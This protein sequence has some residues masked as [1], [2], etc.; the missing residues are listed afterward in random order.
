MTRHDQSE[1]AA[2]ELKGLTHGRRKPR[3][4]VAVPKSGSVRVPFGTQAEARIVGDLPHVAIGIPE[5]SGVA[6]VERLA[7][8]LRHIRA[9]ARSGTD[10]SIHLLAGSDVVREDDAS[11]R[12]GP[13]VFDSGIGRDLVTAPEHDR[14]PA[15][16]EEDRLLHLLATPAKL[17]VEGVRP[18][19]VRDTEGD[20]TDSL[21]HAT[22]GT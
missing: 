7:R 1:D 4:Y 20:E 10:D 11:E 8:D 9:G 17:L 5:E 16:L 13:V 3:R 22:E 21:L 19:E 12:A 2:R 18:S 14:L 15:S 6:A